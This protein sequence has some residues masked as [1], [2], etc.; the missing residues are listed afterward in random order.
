[1]GVKALYLQTFDFVIGV[2]YH[3][4][5]KLEIHNDKEVVPFYVKI[6]DFEP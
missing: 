3:L 5:L 2:I 1:M 6:E 4:I